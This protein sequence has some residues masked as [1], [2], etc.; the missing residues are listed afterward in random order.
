MWK[1]KQQNKGY[2]VTAKNQ[3]AFV[4]NNKFDADRLCALLN[5]N[6]SGVSVGEKLIR[7][8]EALVSLGN[9]LIKLGEDEK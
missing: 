3:G 9:E 1:V 2:L 5:N 7:E 6:E 8:G 4:L